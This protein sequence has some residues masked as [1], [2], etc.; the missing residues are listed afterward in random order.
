MAATPIKSLEL[1]YPVI[2]F[3]IFTTELLIE[4]APTTN[5]T[6]PPEKASQVDE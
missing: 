6:A 5:K 4:T 1:N 3:L 2:Q